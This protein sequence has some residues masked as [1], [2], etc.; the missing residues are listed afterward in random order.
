MNGIAACCIY[1]PHMLLQVSVLCQHGPLGGLIIGYTTA[2]SAEW[3][4]QPR[5]RSNL[6]LT[7]MWD[8]FLNIHDTKS[9]WLHNHISSLKKG[10]RLQCRICKARRYKTINH[11]ANKNTFNTKSTLSTICFANTTF[12]SKQMLGHLGANKPVSFSL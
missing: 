3:K 8:S 6:T 2:N 4:K 7:K 12:S 10:S 11:E 9:P 1:I 5:P